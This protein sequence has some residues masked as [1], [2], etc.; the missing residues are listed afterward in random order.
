M[1][2]GRP[3]ADLE[4]IK[5]A[6]HGA[7]PAKH[8]SRRNAFAATYPVMVTRH[9][10]LAKTALLSEG[11]G[12]CPAQGS[13]LVRHALHELK[14]I[15][16][17]LRAEH[18]GHGIIPCCNNFHYPRVQLPCPLGGKNRG[19]ALVPRI[20]LPPDKP[21]LLKLGQSAGNVAFVH[22][23]TF[24]QFVLSDARVAA[25]V[26][27]EQ[28]LAAIDAKGCECAVEI[29]VVMPV[30]QRDPFIDKFH[31]IFL[32]LVVSRLCKPAPYGLQQSA[33]QEKATLVVLALTSAGAEGHKSL[34][35]QRTALNPVSEARSC[36]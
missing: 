12:A 29:H 28:I 34:R 19:C 16:L 15:F 25:Q 1:G 13:G 22:A 31:D 14:Q 36:P 4:Q 7:P 24:G 3:Y 26:E 20:D 23:D 5:N 27:N 8:M 32:W 9:K 35:A 18:A 17:F 30:G 11:R 6:E 10:R 33:P 2:T 21:F